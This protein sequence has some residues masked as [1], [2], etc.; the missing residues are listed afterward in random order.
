VLQLEARSKKLAAALR[1]PRI[2][3]PSQVY[4][5]ISTAAPDQVMFLLYASPLKPVQDRLRAYFQKYLPAVEEITPRSGHRGSQTGAPAESPRRIHR[6]P[7]G[8]AVRR[9]SPRPIRCHRRRPQNRS[10][11]AARGDRTRPA[12]KSSTPTMDVFSIRSW[13]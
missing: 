7:T 9:V 4:Q 6:Q 1:A 10:W 11:R 13:G 2:R 12:R 5:L 3:K 8:T